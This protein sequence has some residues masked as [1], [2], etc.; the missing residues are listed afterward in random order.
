MI[1]SVKDLSPDQKLAI[2]SLLGRPI[3]E[4]EQVSVRTVP[5]SPEWLMSIQ[6]DSKKNGTDKLTMEEIDAEIAAA[7]RERAPRPGQ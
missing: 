1:H 4:G 5:A 6:Q 3:S 7:R 2:E